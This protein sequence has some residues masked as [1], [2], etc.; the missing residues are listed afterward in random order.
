MSCPDESVCVCDWTDTVYITAFCIY[1]QQ[2]TDLQ[3]A[4]GTH[5]IGCYIWLNKR[6]GCSF[7]IND[8]SEPKD[9][10]RVE[11]GH[12]VSDPSIQTTFL[13]I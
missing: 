7:N 12:R 4:L 11:Q 1:P 2:Q 6:R 3:K 9:K 8:K 13:S 5:T 10:K